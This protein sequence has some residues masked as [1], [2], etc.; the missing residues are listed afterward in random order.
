MDSGKRLRA[1]VLS[2]WAEIPD[3]GSV[4]GDT[5]EEMGSSS[6][7][8]MRL[9]IH[10]VRRCG[11]WKTRW[12][13]RDGVVQMTKSRVEHWLWTE[14]LKTAGHCRMRWKG[15]R[16]FWKSFERTSKGSEVPEQK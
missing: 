8:Y 13:L 16:F 2:I 1:V 5:R 4:K 12:Q 15:S 3:L 6:K 7:V 9:G 14:E 11:R 10:T